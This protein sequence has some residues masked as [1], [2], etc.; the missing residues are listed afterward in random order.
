MPQI[1]TRSKPPAPAPTSLPFTAATLQT[2]CEDACIGARAVAG[3]KCL[4]V[5]AADWTIQPSLG[6]AWCTGQFSKVK[7]RVGGSNAPRPD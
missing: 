4:V 6:G 5:K 2:R 7:L 3:E 1:I